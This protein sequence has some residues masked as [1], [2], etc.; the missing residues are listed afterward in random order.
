MAPKRWLRDGKLPCCTSKLQQLRHPDGSKQ[1]RIA[2][3]WWS[4]N[5]KLVSL[6]RRPS[7]DETKKKKNHNNNDDNK[8]Q[9]RLLLL[10]TFPADILRVLFGLNT[11]PPYPKAKKSEVQKYSKS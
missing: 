3:V 1:S 8:K 6:H 7:S 4:G 5:N 9:R 10:S 11:R 2:A